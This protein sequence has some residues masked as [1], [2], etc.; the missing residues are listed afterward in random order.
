MVVRLLAPGLRLLLL[1]NAALSKY[2][3]EDGILSTVN[4]SYL[5]ADVVQLVGDASKTFP[6]ALNTLLVDAHPALVVVTP[7]LLSPRLRKA[8]ANNVLA[9]LPFSDRAWQVIQTA[10]A[11]T[12]DISAS[13][14]GWSTQVEG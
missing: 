10:Q 7:S 2:A 8:G 5:A 6:T 14:G 1:G 12:L 9:A 11:G 13:T 3:L 4:K